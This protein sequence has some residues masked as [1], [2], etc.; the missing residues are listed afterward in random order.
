MIGPRKAV[1]SRQ[2]GHMLP[3]LPPSETCNWPRLVFGLMGSHHARTAPRCRGYHKS[4]MHQAKLGF[5]GF[6][7]STWSITIVLILKGSLKDSLLNAPCRE[8][9]TV[10]RVIV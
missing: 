9:N 1:E 6:K 10:L 2:T 8:Q 3:S 5:S 7:R 4:W